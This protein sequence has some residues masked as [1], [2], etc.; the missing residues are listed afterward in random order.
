MLDNETQW[1]TV[2]NGFHSSIDGKIPISLIEIPGFFTHHTLRA[3]SNSLKTKPHWWLGGRLVQILGA[4]TPDFEASRWV[5]PLK[6]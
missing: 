5:I 1:Q 2:Y 4:T 3:Y 6:R